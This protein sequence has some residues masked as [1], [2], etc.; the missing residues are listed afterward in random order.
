MDIDIDI[1][2]NRREKVIAA[3]AKQYGEERVVKV[4]TFRTEKSKAA[5]QT[6][7]R[8]LDIDTDIAQYLSSMIT[9]E[10]GI[11]NSLHDTFYGNED[12]GLAPNKRFVSE[13][14]DNYPEV[15]KVAQRIENL[16]CG[17]GQHA[18]GVI[19]V[20][21]DFTEASAV[22]TTTKGDVVSQFEL[23][24]E[25]ELGHIKID[26]LAV[27]ALD[28]IRV[29]LDLLMQYDYVAREK[30][31]RETYENVIGVYN[32]EREDPEMWKMVHNNE[33]MS[34]FQMDQNSGIQAIS[35][36]KPT[37]V[38]DLA[39]INSVMRL[40]ASEKGA[41]QPLNIYAAYKEDISLWYREMEEHQLT[42]E[43]KD[44]LESFVGYEYGVCA[45]QEDLMS[46]L[47]HPMVG[48]MSLAFADKARKG[49]A[50]KL[51]KVFEECEKEFF[52]NAKEKNIPENFANYIWNV[53]FK[54][55]R[56]YSFCAAH[57][58]SYSLIG[59]QE[60]NLAYNFP[61]LFWNT[62]NLIVD[63]Q[64]SDYMEED[65][66][67]EDVEIDDSDDE[68]EEE[69]IVN[70]AVDYKKISTAI[71]KMQ[72]R[73]V[74][75][76]LPNIN[77][78]RYTFIPDIETNSIMYG[79]KGITRVGDALVNDIIQG[80]PY[81]SLVDFVSRV[82]ANKVQ[83]VNL[84]KSGAFDKL[85]GKAREEIMYDYLMSVAETKNRLTL[86]NMPGLIKMELIPEEMKFYQSLFLFNKYLKTMKDG[87]YYNLDRRAEEFYYEHFDIDMLFNNNGTHA[88]LQKEWDKIYKK[89]MDPMREYLK[90]PEKNMLGKMNE[91][92]IAELVDKY[93][94]GTISTWEMSSIGF[95][96]HEHELLG[97]SMD[98]YNVKDFTG[99]DEEPQ[100]ITHITTKN[101]AKIPI[102]ELYRIAGTVVAKDKTKHTITLSTTTGI[103]TVKVWDS[104]FTKYD[105]QLS[106]K[107]PDGTKKV[108]EKSWFSR[109]NK[110]LVTGIRRGDIFIP[111]V[112]R[113]GVY[114]EP[115]LLI[116]SIGQ[117]GL[118]QLQY[119]RYD[120]Q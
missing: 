111:K 64:A 93:A 66:E 102:Y 98:E 14:T 68:E 22:M 46:I 26:C 99:L 44:L 28:K 79:I 91:K 103:V 53:L 39:T 4:G 10:R 27:E 81:V 11:I 45:T 61:I 67:D 8:G 94:D 105:K 78:S 117:D 118:L 104:Q 77:K 12:K 17:V 19:I 112:Y 43:Q 69:K 97:L 83:I 33:I 113:N 5:I 90:D 114:Q 75:I 47:Q 41:E 73:G 57:T 24:D 1:Q 55:Q 100:P 88:I 48:G 34:L 110:L 62:A 40:M 60:M 18:G 115:F 86:Q 59:L 7:C 107:Q 38:E 42:Q 71:G 82:R 108:V 89:A 58:L 13:M 20:D 109:G 29:C 74:V 21:E 16:V 9:A 23:H 31:L 49:I 72:A 2:G 119:E 76:E 3:L 106:E 65:W 30:T 95:Y 6:A 92:I 25:E 84:I 35:L 54:M 37:S 101:G 51:G 96:F 63:S 87:V 116:K 15:W 70:K 56:G 36:T 32:L 52:E 85:E 120:E 80:R 50:K